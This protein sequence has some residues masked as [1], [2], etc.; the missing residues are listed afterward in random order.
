M[1]FDEIARQMVAIS[2]GGSP[3]SIGVGPIE[4]LSPSPDGTRHN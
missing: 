3:T 2:P 4:V 1:S